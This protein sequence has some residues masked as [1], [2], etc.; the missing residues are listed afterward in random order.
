MNSRSLTVRDGDLEVPVL[1]EEFSDSGDLLRTLE[2]R[3]AWSSLSR[4]DYIHGAVPY[5]PE[6]SG[7]SDGSYLRDRLEHGIRD[8]RLA[9]EARRFADEAKATQQERLRKVELKMCGG[10]VS[11]PSYL[12]GFPRNM[13]MVTRQRVPSRVLHMCIDA[14]LSFANSAKDYRDVG[15]AVVKTIAGLEGAGYRVR[16]TAVISVHEYM[17][18]EILMMGLPLK[19]EGEVMDFTRVLYPLTDVSFFRGVGFSWL[20][21]NPA[22]NP[23]D[24]GLGNETQCAF[25]S[26]NVDERLR[27]LYEAAF[28]G[29]AEYLPL[30]DMAKM[31]RRGMSP[32][33]LRGYV[34]ARMLDT[35]I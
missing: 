1:V 5:D 29:N 6:W 17:R 25:T 3:E 26:S 30:R 22:F 14:G 20:A 31:S 2:S 34:E 8:D 27:E 4:F 32:D 18:G 33:G 11:V 15:E 10:V 21:T 7:F 12:S 35:G 13:W 16:V 19:R 28:G 23:A 9:R 24:S